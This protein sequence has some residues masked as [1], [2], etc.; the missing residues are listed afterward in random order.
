MSKE[1]LKAAAECARLGCV[2]KNTGV[3]TAINSTDSVN[4]SISYSFVQYSHTNSESLLASRPSI[5]W[6][7]SSAREISAAAIPGASSNGN[8]RTISIC[9]DPTSFGAV[10]FLVSQSSSAEKPKSKKK[11]KD[12][13]VSTETGYYL[14]KIDVNTNSLLLARKLN[15]HHDAEA[16]PVDTH[17]RKRARSSSATDNAMDAAVYLLVAGGVVWIVWSS[18][19]CE[20]FNSKHGVPVVLPHISCTDAPNLSGNVKVTCSLPGQCEEQVLNCGSCR[21]T[22]EW[23]MEGGE[24]GHIVSLIAEPLNSDKNS[25]LFFAL[26]S[27][28][29]TK[30]A[31]MQL[32]HRVT[33]LFE[34][35]GQSRTAAG[36]ADK[37]SFFKPTSLCAAIGSIQSSGPDVVTSTADTS[38]GVLAGLPRTCKRR[39]QVAQTMLAEE[40]NRTVDCSASAAVPSTPQVAQTPEPASVAPSAKKSAKKAVPETPDVAAAPEVV[41]ESGYQYIGMGKPKSATKAYLE[42]NIDAVEAFVAQLDNVLAAENGAS[43]LKS[44]DWSVLQVRDLPVCCQNVGLWAVR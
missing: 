27:S 15:S 2:L 39:L 16:G 5:K 23:S 8:W 28:G 35:S 24:Q 13:S 9:P 3:V 40:L 7:D 6:M 29:D 4:G 10:L 17:S 19:F 41:S 20:A 31:S 32:W 26:C 22:A 38:G 1:A 12:S 43:L 25:Y 11:S 21:D 37:L 14:L 34:A 30:N 36:T 44:S 33:S 42:S 18:G